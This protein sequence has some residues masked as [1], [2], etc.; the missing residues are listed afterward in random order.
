MKKFYLFLLKNRK[1]F[2]NFL[3]SFLLVAILAFPFLF[4]LKVFVVFLTLEFITKRKQVKNITENQKRW[5]VIMEVTF[6]LFYLFIVTTSLYVVVFCNPPS[7]YECLVFYFFVLIAKIGLT[8]FLLLNKEKP[9]KQ[10]LITILIISLIFMFF[11]SL[12]HYDL[13]SYPRCR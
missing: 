13:F 1:T 6:Y 10:R 11:L 8:R 3:I 9:M 4:F 2:E 12:M 5:L 7:G